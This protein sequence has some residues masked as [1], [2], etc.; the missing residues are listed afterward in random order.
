MIQNQNNPP[1]PFN[2]Y[3]KQPFGIGQMLTVKLMS[4][5]LGN[6]Q[7]P[8]YYPKNQVVDV[9]EDMSEHL[10]IRGGYSQ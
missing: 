4:A 10:E 6:Y 5:R 9:A 7:K 8:H 3:E 2:E 1:I